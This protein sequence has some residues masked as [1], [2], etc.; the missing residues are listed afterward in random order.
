MVN[1]VLTGGEYYTAGYSSGQVDYNYNK[2]AM[3]HVKANLS[4]D[5]N[6]AFRLPIAN[7]S[8]TTFLQS[9]LYPN[10]SYSYRVSASNSVGESNGSATV[11][12]TVSMAGALDATAPN[13]LI[14]S[15]PST[16]NSL[17]VA[18]TALTASD[19]QAVT[20]LQITESATAPAPGAAGWVSTTPTSYTFASAGSKILYAWAMDAAGN[21]SAGKPAS[22]T[23]N[24]PPPVVSLTLSA[25]SSSLAV[26]FTLSATDSVGVTGYLLNE[27]GVAPTVGAAGWSFTAPT[28]YSF[29]GSGLRTLY[30][31]VKDAAGNIT[32]KSAPVTITLS[33]P[34]TVQDLGTGSGT[35]TSLTP[36]TGAAGISCLTG[37]SAGCNLNVTSGNTITLAPLA[38][39][40]STFAGWSG[41]AACTGTGNC[42]VTMSAAKNVIA[43]FTANPATVRIDSKPTVNYYALGST[44]DLVTT[45]GQ[46]VRI[47]NSIFLENVI[48]NS[49][50]E[51]KLLGGFTDAA[52]GARTPTSFTVIDGS[53][54]IRKGR[55]DVERL[56]VR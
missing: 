34:L 31:Y 38:S 30:A 42:V 22:V 17:T 6:M 23:V 46:T 10:Q 26:S 39:A 13:V 45:L 36:Y 47:Q 24:V 54:K 11:A 9:G 56:E 50:V 15:V 2:T 48:M 4:P 7:T 18:I 44:L 52:F 20:G 16:T 55:L 19:N 35:V 40:N 49:P 8:A 32:V 14:F 37:F 27:T 53:L 21:V 29:T 1:G 3:D 5:P 51:I 25:T 33:W 41:T 43:T 12:A 28:A